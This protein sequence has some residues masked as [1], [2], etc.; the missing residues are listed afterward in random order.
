MQ[1]PNPVIQQIWYHC[2]LAE[3]WYVNFDSQKIPGG[4]ESHEI[5]QEVDLGISNENFR[6]VLRQVQKVFLTA[7]NKFWLKQKSGDA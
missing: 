4:K 5:L 3:I 1:Y 6:K 7:Y 2:K